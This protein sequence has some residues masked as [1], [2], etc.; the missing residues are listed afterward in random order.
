VDVPVVAGNL[1][2]ASAAPPAGV[3][4]QLADARSKLRAAV[5][6]ESWDAVMTEVRRTQQDRGIPLLAAFQAVYAK[7][8]AGWTPSA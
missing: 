2:A 1:P 4:A 5:P 3:S 8:A 7:I 6:A